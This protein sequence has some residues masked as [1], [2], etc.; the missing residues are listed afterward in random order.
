MVPEIIPIQQLNLY[1][2][3]FSGVNSLML[4]W[5]GVKEMFPSNKLLEIMALV[6]PLVPLSVISHLTGMPTFTLR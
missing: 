2:P 4:V 1:L 5:P 6:Q 3:D